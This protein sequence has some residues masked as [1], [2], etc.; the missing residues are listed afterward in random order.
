MSSE[1]APGSYLEI[2]CI[3]KCSVC[4]AVCAGQ[5]INL[6]GDGVRI[7]LDTCSKCA[8]CVRVCP[9]GLIGEDALA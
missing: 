9:A 1:A 4:S 6:E 3:W 2:P 5:A 7:D 8:A